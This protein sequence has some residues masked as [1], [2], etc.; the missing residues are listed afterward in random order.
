MT[1]ACSSLDILCNLLGCIQ[2]QVNILSTETCT[3]D[4]C[5][6]AFICYLACMHL[7]SCSSVVAHMWFP[8]VTAKVIALHCSGPTIRFYD[9]CRC[10]NRHLAW[11]TWLLHGDITHCARTTFCSDALSVAERF[12]CCG[13]SIGHC[14]HLHI[15]GQRCQ[16]ATGPQLGP[17]RRI[18]FFAKWH[19]SF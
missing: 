5:M 8:G 13:R 1:G 15:G 16:Y 12:C 19:R 3:R 17:S 7:I 6:L 11:C 2:L 18:V 14:A 4:P 10:V 9:A